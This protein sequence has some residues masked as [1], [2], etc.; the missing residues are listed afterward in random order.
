[1]PLSATLTKVLIVIIGS[2]K[3]LTIL[4]LLTI[5]EDESQLYLIS[6][7]SIWWISIHIK[8]RRHFC[9]IWNWTILVKASCIK[10][11]N[12]TERPQCHCVSERRCRNIPWFVFTTLLLLA[13]VV[14]AMNLWNADLKMLWFPKTSLILI[15]YTF[16]ML[17]KVVVVGWKF[18]VSI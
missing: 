8:W 4:T 10:T 17:V 12:S 6:A 13:L 1:M 9:I 14:R 5:L 16:L 15:D 3:N 18:L 11:I 2:T 7:I